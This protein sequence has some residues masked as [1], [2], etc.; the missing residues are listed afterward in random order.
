MTRPALAM[1]T[2]GAILAAAPFASAQDMTSAPQASPSAMAPPAQGM[3]A[4]PGAIADAPVPN[5]PPRTDSPDPNAR[6][7]TGYTGD[8]HGAAFRDI[9]Q[10][11]AALQPRVAGHSK[12]AA[13][14]KAIK[15][16]EA[17]RRARHGG[18]L[19]DWD[20]ELLNKKLDSLDAMLGAG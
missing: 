13:Q 3:A 20:R 1:L 15:S 14:L 11:I 2:F 5:P 6:A 18:E 12:A 4:D 10:R 19:R 17:Y 9:D 16:D 8:A 7:D